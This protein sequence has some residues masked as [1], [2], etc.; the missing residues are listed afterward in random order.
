ML[1]PLQQCIIYG[2]M[3][4]VTFSQPLLKN[5][6]LGKKLVKLSGMQGLEVLHLTALTNPV[7]SANTCSCQGGCRPFNSL[8]WAANKALTAFSLW[9]RGTGSCRWSQCSASPTQNAFH[10]FLAVS[11]RPP[12]PSRHQSGK[13]SVPSRTVSLKKSQFYLS[14]K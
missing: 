12:T 2:G 3:W 7:H 11:A 10:S 5:M 9:T 1:L 14:A 4:S 13:L 8:P 6:C